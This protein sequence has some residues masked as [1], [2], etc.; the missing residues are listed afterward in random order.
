MIMRVLYPY[1]DK[2]IAVSNGV[3]DDLFKMMGKRS[4]KVVTIY[5]PVDFDDIKVKV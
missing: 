2:I 1:A 3:A 5:N 4:D